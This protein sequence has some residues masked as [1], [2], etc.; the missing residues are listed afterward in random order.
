MTNRH[1]SVEIDNNWLL[2]R[3][4]EQECHWYDADRQAVC[5]RPFVP[6]PTLP[7]HQDPALWALGALNLILIS[8][9]IFLISLI[10]RGPHVD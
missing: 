3:G 6:G 5:P 4:C 2:C 8:G 9:V 7:A 1:A 10:F